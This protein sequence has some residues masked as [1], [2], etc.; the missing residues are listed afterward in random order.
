MFCD[1]G[2][3]QPEQTEKTL[4]IEKKRIITTGHV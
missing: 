2:E 1:S 3:R 4:I